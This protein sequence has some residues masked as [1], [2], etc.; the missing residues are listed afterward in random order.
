MTAVDGETVVVRIDDDEFSLPFRS[1]DRAR[2][3]PELEI[4]Q[5]L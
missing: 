2:A 4:G 5:T 1:V 3:L